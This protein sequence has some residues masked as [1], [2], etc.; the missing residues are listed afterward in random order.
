MTAG[1]RHYGLAAARRSLLH[2]VLG[3]GGSALAGIG[4]LMLLVRVMPPAEYGTLVAWLA[5]LE[6]HYLVS[7][8]GLSGIAQRYVPE[9]R[10]HAAPADLQRLVRRALLL[11]LVVALPLAGAAGLGASALATFF[12]TVVPASTAGLPFSLV[13]VLLLCTGTMVRYLDELLA[14]LLMQGVSQ[15]MALLRN[16]GKL[17][18]LA[19]ALWSHGSVSAT[20]M[21]LLE[22]GLAALTGLVALR[23]MW[24]GLHLPGAAGQPLLPRQQRP[25]QPSLPTRWL[26]CGACACGFM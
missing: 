21:L 17:P 25:R 8:V 20:D 1:A 4:V 23:A 16:L 22:S 10:T 3:R 11:R 13:L 19:V 26:A 24:R 2:F 7:G 9:F 14:A 12:G 5:F 6:I 18:W 15:A